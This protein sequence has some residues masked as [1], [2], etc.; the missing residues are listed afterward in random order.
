MAGM[1]LL[2]EIVPDRATQFDTAYQIWQAL[3]R[4]G[5]AEND[6]MLPY[7]R[8]DQGIGG[9]ADGENTAVTGYL[10]SREKIMLVVFN[11][12][13]ISTPVKITL[14]T[15]K[16]FNWQGNIKVRDLEH[17]QEVYHGKPEFMVNVPKRGFLLLEAKPEK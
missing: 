3:D 15:P 7:W 1:L 5:F 10:K 9:S 16:L 11:N 17:Q 14:D 8:H 12:H 2:H 13:D 4:F 6:R